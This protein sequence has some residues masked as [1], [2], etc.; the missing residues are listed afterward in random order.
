[1]LVLL[2]LH[3]D[4]MAPPPLTARGRLKTRPKVLKNVEPKN[5]GTFLKILTNIFTKMLMKVFEKMLDPTFCLKSIGAT[6]PKNVG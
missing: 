3:R 4:R 6:F 1:M 5:V 2:W